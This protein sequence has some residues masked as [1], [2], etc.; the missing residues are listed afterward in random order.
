MIKL[1]RKPSLLNFKQI[2]STFTWGCHLF[3]IIYV[4]Y[5]IMENYTTT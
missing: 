4:V 1:F 2:V 3:Y 5:V